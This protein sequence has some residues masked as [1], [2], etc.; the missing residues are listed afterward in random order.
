MNTPVAYA[1]R[2][3]AARKAAQELASEDRP[4]TRFDEQRAVHLIE[5]VDRC[6]SLTY[7]AAGLDAEG[8]RVTESIFH[9]RAEARR[10][11]ADI[12]K[13]RRNL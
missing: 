3:T 1:V 2:S 7:K 10:A 11:W 8:M 4:F 12:R 5:Y 9:D 13:A 6:Y